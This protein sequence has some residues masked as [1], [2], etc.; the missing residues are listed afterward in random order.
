MELAKNEVGRGPQRACHELPGGSRFETQRG[1]QKGGGRI[2]AVPRGGLELLIV[3][4]LPAPH[5]Y[6]I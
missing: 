5:K 4:I 6:L 1:A 2:R 3:P